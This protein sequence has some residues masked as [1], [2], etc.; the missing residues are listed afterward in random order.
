MTLQ[1]RM[2]VEDTPVSLL[3]RATDSFSAWLKRKSSQLELPPP[4]VP[5]LV[6]GVEVSTDQVEDEHLSLRR[7]VLSEDLNNGRWTTT[8][9][10]ITTSTQ[11]GWLW[12]DLEWVCD[13]PWGKTPDVG[14]PALVRL[15]L[16]GKTAHVGN[17]PLPPSPIVIPPEAVDSLIQVL[18][19]PAR[20]VPVVVLS[21]DH[22]VTPAVSLHRAEALTRELLGVAPVYV[23]VGSATSELNSKLDVGL[24]VVGGAARTYLPGTGFGGSPMRRH[25]VLGGSHL[26][27]DLQGSS[28]LL[29]EPLRRQALATPPP[30]VYRD[31]G[32]LLLRRLSSGVDEDALLND[33]LIAEQA[34]EEARAEAKQLREELEWQAMADADTERTL[35][36]AQGRL[37]W[38]ESLLAE[39]GRH[40]QGTATPDQNDIDITG[41]EELLIAASRLTHVEL[42]KVVTGALALD[43][44]PQAESWARKA[45]RSLVALDEY[46]RARAGGWSGD[47]RAWCIEPAD[48]NAAVVPGGW[49]ALRESD[50]VNDNPK[51]RDP[52]TFPV[53]EG[54]NKSG[55]IYMPAHIKIVEGGRPAPRLHFHDGTSG[56]T[57][58]IHVGYLGPHLPNDQTN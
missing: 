52:R 9:T 5:L 27:E 31:H 56:A 45:W 15:L 48:S 20:A 51:Y 53:P 41:F 47:F 39:Q 43:Q 30:A 23:L 32:R 14:V 22:V 36:Q 6:G 54:V 21:R 49:V 26:R 57:Q 44:Y 13:D 29:A 33:V 58:K 16:A 8:L 1:Y 40:V 38:L 55:Q 11:Q 35:H 4:G 42:G 2:I 17:T 3:D 10:A 19:D 50:S 24:H 25:R 12:V 46:A 7:H 18:K 28:L 37:R 34:V